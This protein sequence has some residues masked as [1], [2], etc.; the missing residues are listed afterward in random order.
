MHGRHLQ[1]QPALR[2]HLLASGSVASWRYG[3]FSFPKAGRWRTRAGAITSLGQRSAIIAFHPRLID[4]PLCPDIV[5]LKTRNCTHW[6]ELSMSPVRPKVW[7]APMMAALLA[8]GC[9]G[10]GTRTETMS[11]GDLKVVTQPRESD[12]SGDRRVALAAIAAE[13]N[14]NATITASTLLD[15]AEYRYPNLFS[16][17]S[18][19]L[20]SVIHDGMTLYAR[21]YSHPGGLR[22]LGVTTDGLIFGLGDFTNNALQSY[23]VIADWQSQ[24]VAD[25]CGVY[26]GSCASPS[27]TG[28]TPSHAAY[29]QQITLSGTGLSSISAVTIN[30]RAASIAS[31]SATSV[32]V[33]VPA[34]ATSGAI[35]ATSSSGLTFNLGNFVADPF[36]PPITITKAGTYSG[37]WESLDPAVAAVTVKTTEPVTIQDC[38]MRGRGHLIDAQAGGANLTVRMCSGVG[39]DPMVNGSIRGCFLASQLLGSLI[40]ENNY[41]EGVSTAFRLW[42]SRM[43]TPEGSLRIRF[44]RA[45]NL[46]G[47]ASDGNGGRIFTGLQRP[48]SDN[49]NSFVSSGPMAIVNGFEIAWNYVQSDPATSSIGDV[50][51]LWHVHGTASLPIR[52]HDNF[53]IGG[54]PPVPTGT[55]YY[56]GAITMDG[57]SDDTLE[58]ATGHVKIHDNQI[59]AHANVGINMA[60]G[61]DIEAFNNRIVSSGQFPDGKWFVGYAGI[62]LVNWSIVPRSVNFN[63]WAHDNVV[64]YQFEWA[65]PD[66]PNVFSPPVF[67]QDYVLTDCA[68]G[69]SGPLSLCTGNVSLPGPITSTTEANEL[70]IWQQKLTA[71]NIVIGPTP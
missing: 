33:S 34:N 49:G 22:Y 7:L 70:A 27:F 17:R 18:Q 20:P 63:S 2:G 62:Q 59:V 45:K 24:V 71:N 15:W 67:R 4:T 12:L 58:T 1:L 61:H 55:T 65:Y 32:V 25:Q 26:P 51:D 16:V 66:T 3:R 40:A 39:L 23:G 44:N 30:G 57:W 47:L 6:D 31:R 28:F 38:S 10:G 41:I 43:W 56:A 19:V 69:P 54:Y 50:I 37:N 8:A 9:G 21:V 35:I 36:G 14:A 13:T 60:V 52:I 5:P 53:I 46:D 68:G 29:G 64:G 48:G 42:N 11:D